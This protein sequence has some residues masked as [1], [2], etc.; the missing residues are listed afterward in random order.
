VHFFGFW[1]HA[2]RKIWQPWLES[3]KIHGGSEI[4]RRGSD[5]KYFDGLMA[6]GPKG[7]QSLPYVRHVGRS[8]KEKKEEERNCFTDHGNR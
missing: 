5:K 1:Y 4:N 3:Q 7:G 2:P 8:M 6:R